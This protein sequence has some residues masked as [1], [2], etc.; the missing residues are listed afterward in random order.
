MN[1]RVSP[2]CVQDPLPGCQLPDKLSQEVIQDDE[3]EVA[4]VLNFRL[5]QPEQV[6]PPAPAAIGH[7]C[8]VGDQGWLYSAQYPAGRNRYVTRSARTAR[9]VRVVDLDERRGGGVVRIDNPA[10]VVLVLPVQQGVDFAHELVKF[11]GGH[12]GRRRCFA[13]QAGIPA[14]GFCPYSF[15]E[16]IQVTPRQDAA[17]TAFHAGREVIATAAHMYQPD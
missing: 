9:V 8:I 17:K 4:D 14:V 7:G 12:R 6:L 2:V 10:I 16:R 1:D 13:D 15:P 11:R 3:V 5:F